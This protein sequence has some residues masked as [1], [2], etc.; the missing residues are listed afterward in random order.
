MNELL[1]TFLDFGQ[2]NQGV[3]IGDHNLPLVLLS[4][5]V[6]LLGV[7]TSLLTLT[8]ANSYRQPKF[9]R[10]W[11]FISACI[12]GI[13]VWS[14]HFIGMIAFQI[15]VT[16]KHHVG[17]TLVSVLPAIFANWYALGT[18]V[19]VD[20][21][22]QAG[23]IKTIFAGLIL[24]LGIGA[25]HYIGMAAMQFNGVLLY[26]VR[27]FV[28]SIIVALLLGTIAMLTYRAMAEWAR[29][30]ELERL[31]S[32]LLP[33]AII[34]LAISGMHYTAMFAAR[35]Y[36]T[37]YNSGGHQHDDW[38]AY[39]IGFA[40]ML[41]AIAAVIGTLVDKRLY[42]QAKS[43][44]AADKIIH[45]LATQDSLTG[46]ANRQMLLDKLQQLT[47]YHFALAI[48]DLDKFKALNNTYGA[49]YG[50]L[51]LQQVAKRLRNVFATET[52]SSS[53][54]SR[55][56][57]NEFAIILPCPH[58]ADVAAS[59]NT[60][61]LL[62]KDI[63]MQLEQSYQLGHFTHL[64]TVSVGITRFSAGSDADTVLGQA[65]LALAHAK[66]DHHH[67]GIEIFRT[68]FA[69][70]ATQRINLEHDLR[71][72]IE[73]QE[74]QLYVQAQVN[75]DDQVVGAEAL[76]R[77]PH[78]KHGFI[79]PAEFIPLAEETGLIISLG[80]L[81]IEQ[82]C[83]L[84]NN[85]Q[86]QPQTQQLTLA[87][88][89]S[90]HQFQQ[91]DFVQGLLAQIKYHGIQP[92]L[93]KLEVTESVMVHDVDLVAEKMNELQRIGV[94]FAIDDF[95]TG[96]SSMAYLAELPFE[97][98]KIDLSFIRDMLTQP[99]MASIVRAMI[100]L[101]HSLDLKIIAEG[102]ETQAQRD[103]LAAHGCDLYQGYLFGRPAPASD[104]L[105][106]LS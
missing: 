16:I 54:V 12:A 4:Y 78:P 61:L 39:T 51:M 103:Y 26:D 56:G 34:A 31:F 32:R 50:D 20:A 105:K 80:H 23:L 94:H 58:E 96:Y 37:P 62:I 77:W 88:N 71:L 76:L 1:K 33:A 75:S 35:F 30:T 65:S 25:M 47:G 67:S 36:A 45:N 87:V 5:F 40:A 68:E 72:A 92:H 99:S 84:L 59:E 2:A 82:A 27:W 79:S 98:L 69:E 55:L 10:M 18:Q 53:F 7:Y 85:W 24:G 104:F 41:A 44:K 8:R 22:F 11:I 66:N 29:R 43:Q 52:N 42:T 15:P 102:V 93:L 46:L 57:G 48:F 97:T 70:Q 6:A 38:L 19:K 106:S 89:V 63:Q 101:A 9:R 90:G 73:K 17:I 14:M 91:P 28:K 81:I 86:Q 13:T 95:G 74:L 83:E 100:Q 3:V 21:P 49:S 60:V 64:S